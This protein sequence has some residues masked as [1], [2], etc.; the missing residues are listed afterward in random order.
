V[1]KCNYSFDLDVVNQYLW[2]SIAVGMFFSFLLIYTLS[3]TTSF[4]ELPKSEINSVNDI[5]LRVVFHFRAGDEEITTFKVFNQLGGY[6]ET[7][8]PKFELQG[9]I[10]GNKQLLHEA[11]DALYHDS[12]GKNQYS[13]FDV[14]VYLLDKNAT[15]VNFNYQKC[16]IEDY[17]METLFDKE[18]TYNE[19]TKFVHIENFEIECSGYHPIHL[20]ESQVTIDGSKMLSNMDK[21][22]FK[23]WEDYF[24]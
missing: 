4:A 14:D 12:S 18:E 13:E 24:R 6:D 9:I 11:I 15:N 1:I 17:F 19:K 2:I 20:E 22:E 7:T 5:S 21:E 16:D 10:D 3:T 8:S 23:T